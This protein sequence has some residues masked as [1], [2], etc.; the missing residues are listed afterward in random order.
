MIQLHH[1][2]KA[3]IFG[4]QKIKSLNLDTNLNIFIGGPFSIIILFGLIY[5]STEYNLKETL[6]LMIIPLVIS[7][8][9]FYVNTLINRNLILKNIINEIETD[10][11]K[12]STYATINFKSAQSVI[13]HY[14]ELLIFDTYEDIDFNKVNKKKLIIIKSFFNDLDFYD[15]LFKR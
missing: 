8:K 9:L 3:N 10:V 12:V 11:L 2:Y 15:K 14:D 13:K 1:R 4:N 7:I 6:L 5:L